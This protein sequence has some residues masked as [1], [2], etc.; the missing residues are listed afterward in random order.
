M[1]RMLARFAMSFIIVAAVLLWEAYKLAVRHGDSW[2][3][4]IY[5]VATVCAI[6]LGFVGFREKHRM[7]RD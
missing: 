6:A 7:N 1:N 4:T 3:I 5:L 2:R